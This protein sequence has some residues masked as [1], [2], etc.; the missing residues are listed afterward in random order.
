M[1]IYEVAKLGLSGRDAM[2]RMMQDLQELKWDI[3]IDER[4][5]DTQV[6]YLVEMA[7]KP[8]P[9]PE[10]T[11]RLKGAPPVSSDEEYTLRPHSSI[12]CC[13]CI[14]MSS[15]CSSSEDVPKGLAGLQVESCHP[16]FPSL[17]AFID[18]RV[19]MGI[20]PKNQCKEPKRIPYEV[21]FLTPALPRGLAASTP[22]PLVSSVLRMA[23]TKSTPRIKSP[24]E[25]LAEGTQD[26]PCFTPCSLKPVAEVA[27]TSTGFSSGESSSFSLDGSSRR[28]SSEGAST[29]SSSHEGP[30]TPGRSVLKKR[31]R[32]PV[33]PVP[34]IV[35]EGP[36][37][38]RAPGCSDPQDGPSSHFPYPKLIPTVKR[39]TLE[40]KYLLPVGYTFIIP[41]LDATVNE[42]PAKCITV[43]RANLNYG[44]RFPL[45]LVIEDILTE[46]EQAPAKVVFTSWQNICSFITTCELHGLTCTA[47]VFNL[48]HTIQRALKETGD[49]GWHCFNNRQ[50]YMTAIEKKSKVKH[51][52]YGF[53]FIRW[54]LG[55]GNI[56]DWN[57]G[58]PI[59]NPFRA[60][61][62]KEKKTA[63]YFLYFFQEDDKP[64]PIPK[65]IAQAIKSV[66]GP[67][68]RKSKSSDREPLNF[69]PKLKFF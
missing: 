4:L 10:V 48:V 39:T 5:R 18:G 54:E 65:F 33:G 14:V 52:K 55:W 41:E 17:P 13:T 34:E 68:K 8:Y 19:V 1:V 6:P 64:R 27:S 67:E 36:K 11:S 16:Q 29:I 21:P 58:K 25:L 59:K 30:S 63:Y 43:Y 40:K 38:P 66:K 24:D 69:V 23:K 62:A 49:L 57:E 20:P 26:N 51:W 15:S 46:Y 37:F 47:Q 31:S 7:Y 12:I 61:T 9:H 56:P 28:S 2:R 44:L 60:P 35:A 3:D 42:P 53:L 50:G 45:Y 22:L 32:S